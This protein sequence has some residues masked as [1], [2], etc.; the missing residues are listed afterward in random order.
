M[1]N[2]AYG[3]CVTDIVRDEIVFDNDSYDP[4][5]TFRSE[6]Q[7]LEKAIDKY[8]NGGKRFLFYPWGVWVTAYARRNLFSGIK[9]CRDDYV[10]AD[11]DSIKILHPERHTRYFE[12]YNQKILDKINEAAKFQH[13]D[14]SEFS[15]LTK[16]GKVKTIGVW[17]DDGEY[18]YFKTLGSNDRKT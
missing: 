15:P 13:I 18:W 17:D 8:N 3:M 10:Y 2:S 11:T 12:E 9:E 4:R 5:E 16:E 1:L 14:P 6:K 7:Q